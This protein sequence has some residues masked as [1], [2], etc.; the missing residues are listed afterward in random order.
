[1]THDP[2]CAPPWSYGKGGYC[3]GCDLIAKAR[4]DERGK[5]VDTE[6]FLTKEGEASIPKRIVE[7]IRADEREQAAQ[8]IDGHSQHGYRCEC[9]ADLNNY[10]NHLQNVIRGEEQ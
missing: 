10:E 7:F 9:G 8:R 3:E 6:R 1:M 5:F 2:L 4:S